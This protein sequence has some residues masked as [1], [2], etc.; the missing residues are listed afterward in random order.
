MPQKE[1]PEWYG[2]HD[3]PHHAGMRSHQRRIAAAE[4]EL[5]EWTGVKGNKVRL[6]KTGVIFDQKEHGADRE[7]RTPV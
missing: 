2:G 3:N 7:N 5:E 4:A 1:V 6:P